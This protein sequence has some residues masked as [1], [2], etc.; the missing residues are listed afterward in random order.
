MHVPASS[1]SSSSL[2]MAEPTGVATR[3]GPGLAGVP[4]VLN[5]SVLDFEVIMRFACCINCCGTGRL[6]AR[7]VRMLWHGSRVRA[8]GT[9]G[10]LYCVGISGGAITVLGAEVFFSSIGADLGGLVFVCVPP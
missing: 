1:S 6:G 5:R 2:E 4:S 9:D 8:V 7:D 10:L 3:F